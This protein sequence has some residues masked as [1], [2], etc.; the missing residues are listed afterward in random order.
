MSETT[1]ITKTP[2][3]EAALQRARGGLVHLIPGL[4]LTAGVA[5]LAFALRRFPG[6]G[7]LSP[8]ILATVIGMTLHNVFGTPAWATPGVKFSLKRVLRLGII[9]LGLQLMASQVAAVGLDG[10]AVIAATLVATFTFTK[11]LGRV[12]GVDAKLA[13]LIGAGTSI[14]GASAVIATNTVTN[15][16]DEDVAYAVACV[17]VFGSLSMLIYPLLPGLLHLS[18]AAFGLWSGAS[19]H[20]I[21]QVVAAAFQDGTHA[22]EV[23]TVAKLT[24][25]MM[26]APVVFTLG[27]MAVRRAA[28]SEDKSASRAAPP[29]P[30]FVLGFIG[31]VILNSFVTI[32]TEP[33]AAITLTTTFLLSMALAAMG[34][35]TDFRKLKAEGLKPLV[36]A[37]AAWVFIAVF[38]LA[39]VK[40]T[41]YS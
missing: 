36:L 13:E 6:M 39:L 23:A 15:G 19:I 14:C 21:A 9:L 20:E 4:L 31:M 18:P 41:A 30:W 40:L 38:A 8:M 33:K 37:A 26:L 7:M 35:E 25:V 2:V 5:G 16:R 11:W 12:M 3:N 10:V 32:P 34:I 22:G 29:M 27:I 1:L 28:H 24:R 17:T